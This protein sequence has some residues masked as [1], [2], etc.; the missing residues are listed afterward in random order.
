ML[1]QYLASNA[2]KV[3]LHSELLSKVW[4]P[5]YHDDVQYLRV[6]IS[7]VRRKLGTASGEAGPI[8]TYPGIGY[9][10]VAD[11]GA[12]MDAGEPE[13]GVAARSRS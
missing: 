12:T 9:S 7:R 1:L 2:G 11:S 4:G 10:L 13:R 5:A 8:L 6:W 3:V